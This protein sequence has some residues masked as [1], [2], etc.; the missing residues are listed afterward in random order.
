MEATSKPSLH[1]TYVETGDLRIICDLIEKYSYTNEEVSEVINIYEPY[2][3]DGIPEV[4]HI[5]VLLRHFPKGNV[6]Q[7]TLDAIKKS[8]PNRLEYILK[9]INS[10]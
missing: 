6:S 8:F 7:N 10:A 5:T 1:D 3:D 4:D 2:D 9:L